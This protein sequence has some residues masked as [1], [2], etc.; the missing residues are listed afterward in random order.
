MQSCRIDQIVRVV[1]AHD[2]YDD[3]IVENRRE[4][5]KSAMCKH[6]CVLTAIVEYSIKTLLRI[7]KLFQWLYV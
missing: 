5:E 3:F 6:V 1:L 2:G 4:I 7:E